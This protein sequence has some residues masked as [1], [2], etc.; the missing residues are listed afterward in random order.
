MF[1]KHFIG[2]HSIRDTQTNSGEII[3]EF[4]ESIKNGVDWNLSLIQAISN[5]TLPE[6][7]YNERKYK[8]FILGEAFDWLVLAER[9]CHEV[10]GVL[11]TRMVE[12]LLVFNDFGVPG[13]EF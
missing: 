1:E 12:N 6:E 9:L 8:F 10:R 11:P 5:W 4:A 2:F 13:R 7:I 3:K